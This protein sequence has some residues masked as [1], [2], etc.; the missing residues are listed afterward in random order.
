M[1]V[2]S[3]NEV[4]R[5][6]AVADRHLRHQYSRALIWTAAAYRTGGAQLPSLRSKQLRHLDAASD[7]TAEPI[8]APPRRRA[9]RPSQLVRRQK[10]FLP[11]QV[12]PGPPQGM[13][14]NGTDQQ[15]KTSTGTALFDGGMYYLRNRLRRVVHCQLERAQRKLRLH[16]MHGHHGGPDVPPLRMPNLGPRLTTRRPPVLLRPLRSGR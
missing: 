12:W 5:Q 3:T 11:E 14:G 10:T 4:D 1:R 15:L 9:D 13:P 2:V 6:S 7:H 8:E 16:R